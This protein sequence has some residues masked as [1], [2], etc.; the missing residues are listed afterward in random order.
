MF[1][2]TGKR[3]A[4]NTSV[5][6][7]FVDAINKADTAELLSLMSPDHVLVDSAGN[8]MSGT[9]NL[10]QAWNGY[11]KLFPDYQIEITDMMEK[12]GSVGLFGHAR[13]TF[14]GVPWN[15]P[16]A[17]LAE[18]HAGKV[19]RWQVYADNSVVLEIMGRTA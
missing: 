5:V 11:F 10:E 2:G 13:A 9:K 18:I 14:K 1:I 6:L 17:W 8:H 3:P 19:K 4:V 12:E 15:I 7:A 16:A